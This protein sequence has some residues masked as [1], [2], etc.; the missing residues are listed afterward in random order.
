ARD[1]VVL[2]LTDQHVQ[3]LLAV[4]LELDHRVDA[5]LALEDVGH[6]LRRNRE[7]AR[8]TALAVG[9][10]RDLARGAEAPRG[11]LTLGG[12][13]G[14]RNFAEF[15]FSL[16]L[17]VV[18]VVPWP[19]SHEQRADRVA[20]VNSSNRLGEELGNRQKP[21]LVA[22]RRLFRGADRVRDDD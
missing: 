16:L 8:R 12:T 21:D 18:R 19:A 17:T 13:G 9:H 3:L 4:D 20:V 15:H 7:R 22:R 6:L 2:I 11:T 14:G 5:T 1:R 10:G